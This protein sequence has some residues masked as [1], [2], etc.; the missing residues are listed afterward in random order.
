MKVFSFLLVSCLISTL[1]SVAAPVFTGPGPKDPYSNSIDKITILKLVNEAR[2][3]GCQCGDTYYNPAPPLTWNELL[4]KAAAVHSNDM[5]TK[6]YFSHTAPD[7]S[8]AGERIEK[9]GYHWMMYGENIGMGFK[10]ER[11][12][13]EGWLKSPGHCKNIM[14][15]D[16]KEMGAA[17]AGNYW[18]QTFGT[19]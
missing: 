17:K 8:R 5:F 14:N 16:Y 1:S 15:K 2:K 12:M 18:T 11:E 4:E 7:G 9:E 3:K 13:V 10:N 19:R 6:K